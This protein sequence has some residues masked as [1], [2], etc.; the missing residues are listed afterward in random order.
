MDGVLDLYRSYNRDSPY[1][2][3]PTDDIESLLGRPPTSVEQWVTANKAAF[4]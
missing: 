1:T 2:N 3:V 4:M